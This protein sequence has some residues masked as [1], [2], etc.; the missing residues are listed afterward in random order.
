MCTA[1]TDGGK[2]GG[3]V[4]SEI[5]GG[6]LGW[7]LS[8]F[9]THLGGMVRRLASSIQT[10]RGRR[11]VMDNGVDKSWICLMVREDFSAKR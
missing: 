11:G 2:G 10:I 7:L 5:E 1:G 6:E 9:K 3:R 4:A 8:I